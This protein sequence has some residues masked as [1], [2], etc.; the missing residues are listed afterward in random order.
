M[1]SPPLAAFR[2]A[3]LL[4]LIW[5]R[6]A[7]PRDFRL[8]LNKT[9]DIPKPYLGLL[10]GPDRQ[11]A[12]YLATVDDTLL[13]GKV[14]V[15]LFGSDGAMLARLGKA[16]LTD[17]KDAN[18]SELSPEERRRLHKGLSKGL[19]QTFPALTTA[20][21]DTLLERLIAHE[22]TQ[23][24]SAQSPTALTLQ[25][26]PS[27]KA[28]QTRQP[29]TRPRFPRT[30]L[31]RRVRRVG[32]RP[33]D[34]FILDIEHCSH[35]PGIGLFFSGYLA[36]APGRLRHLFLHLPVGRV[37]VTDRLIRTSRPLLV[38]KCRWAGVPAE[39]RPGL[40]CFVPTDAPQAKLEQ[41]FLSVELDDGIIALATLYPVINLAD[42][43][44]LLDHD[45][46]FRLLE[47]FGPGL[48]PQAQRGLQPLLSALDGWLRSPQNHLIIQQGACATEQVIVH[49][50]TL[51]ALSDHALHLSGWL[52]DDRQQIAD[53]RLFTAFGACVDVTGQIPNVPRADVRHYLRE[54]GHQPLNDAVGFY[55]R[56]EL[57]L[58]LGAETPLYLRVRL[59]DGEVRRLALR[60]RAVDADRPM[61]AIRALL[62]GFPTW[63]PRLFDFY[64]QAVGPT[65]EQLWS[66]RRQPT[67]APLVE[68]CGTMPARP[69]VSLIVP[70][71]GRIDLL[72]H[73][74]AHFADDADFQRC[75]LIYVLDDPRLTN[76][77]VALCRR[78][79]PLFRVPFKT[80]I[81][82][83]NLGYAG[84]TNL[85]ARQASGDSLVL[86]NSD[87]LPREPGWL[88][89]LMAVFDT[90]EQP[91]ALGPKLLFADGLIQHAGMSFF[92]EPTLPGFWFNDHPDKGLPNDRTENPA[93]RQVDAVTGA[94]LLL[95]R[96][97]YWEVG[98]LSEDYILG[99]FE[100]SDLCLKLRA[101][102]YGIWYTP[103]VELYHLERLSFPH[104]GDLGWRTNL[105][106]Y[107]AWVQTRRWGAAIQQLTDTSR[108]DWTLKPSPS[109]SD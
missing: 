100:D 61:P 34:A 21:I 25:T 10:F 29:L 26:P 58:P 60:A 94:C 19:P 86:L 22:P 20:V 6:E 31:K 56:V 82:G 69:L 85:G 88:T 89:R 28:I 41:A 67:L 66:D 23:P 109:F 52:A 74:L 12:L 24:L 80:V 38:R 37:D 36:A 2:H 79:Y 97:V 73:Q 64:D 96:S 51:L 103:Q 40:E 50:D 63:A 91:G 68:T 98:G 8:V 49:F 76:D 87:V 105:S 33:E 54:Q 77:F 62:S 5:S 106:R 14:A 72:S 47:G 55:L 46:A 16:R 59:H 30:Q 75:E 104:A 70:L 90:L 93:P 18:L 17:W 4:V 78:E 42:G 84:A 11:H 92:Q 81:S 32:S 3:S 65:I 9:H 39:D 83:V 45:Q 102:G 1:I 53:I 43:Q 101:A 7:P 57:P 99:D 35:L 95:K 107:N 48:N 13:T 15:K 44:D 71:Y 27:A 108:P